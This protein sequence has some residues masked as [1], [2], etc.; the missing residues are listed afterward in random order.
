MEYLELSFFDRFRTFGFPTLEQIKKIIIQLLNGLIYLK[1]KG[2]MHRDLKPE[3]IMFRKRDK[4]NLEVVIV[5][6]GLAEFWEHEP[7]L[8]SRCGTPGY[9]APEILS[10]A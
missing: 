7:F 3:N 1:Q 2:I 6:F 5:D 4:N 10:I 9:V 8:F